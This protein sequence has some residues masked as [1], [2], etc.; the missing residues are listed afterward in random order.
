MNW[1]SISRVGKIVA[2]AAFFLPWMTVSCQGQPIATLNGVELATGLLSPETTDRLGNLD[3]GAG[4]IQWLV[5]VAAI[6]GIAGLVIGWRRFTPDP[7]RNALIASCVAAGCVFVSPFALEWGIESTLGM[8]GAGRDVS[9]AVAVDRQ[10]GFWVALAGFATAAFAWR[11]QR[12][13]NPFAGSGL[14]RQ[15]SPAGDEAA[16][17]EASA[18]A[19]S[20]SIRDYLRE[21]PVGRFREIAVDSLKKLGEQPPEPP[22]ATA[23]TNA[24][25]M[26]AGGGSRASFPTIKGLSAETVAPILLFAAALATIESLSWMLYAQVLDLYEGRSGWSPDLGVDPQREGWLQALAWANVPASIVGLLLAGVFRTKLRALSLIVAGTLVVAGV[27]LLPGLPGLW[28]LFIAPLCLQVAVAIVWCFALFS[29]AEKRELPELIFWFGGLVAMQAVLSFLLDGWLR[30]GWS[31]EQESTT[32]GA[33]SLLGAQ[34]IFRILCLALAAILVMLAVIWKRDASL[35]E[36][37]GSRSLS[38]AG[39]QRSTTGILLRDPA[40]LH[41]AI[42]LFLTGLFL[43][44][45]WQQ[46]WRGV[47]SA[48][49]EFSDSELMAQPI[50][51]WIRL[52][53]AIGVLTGALVVGMLSRQTPAWRGLGPA[54]ALAAAPIGILASLTSPNS[55]LNAV[56]PLACAYFP[57]AVVYAHL[58]AATDARHRF[59]AA[60]ASGILLLT[61]AAFAADANALVAFAVGSLGETGA[62]EQDIR[63]FAALMGAGLAFLW[64]SAHFLLAAQAISQTGRERRT[65]VPTLIA[66]GLA[67]PVS[68]GFLVWKH[69][70]GAQTALQQMVELVAPAEAPRQ[71][72][73]DLGVPPAD[74]ESAAPDPS[75]PASTPS[76]TDIETSDEYPLD[77]ITIKAG[78]T[79][80]RFRMDADCRLWFD[81]IE[82]SRLISRYTSRDGDTEVCEYGTMV[83]TSPSEKWAVTFGAKSDYGYDYIGIVSQRDNRII[84]TPAIFPNPDGAFVPGSRSSQR[85]PHQALR[86]LQVWTPDEEFLLIAEGLWNGL[87]CVLDVSKVTLACP[88]VAEVERAVVTA[89]RA[90]G[91]ACPGNSLDCG[92]SWNPG[93]GEMWFGDSNSTGVQVPKAQW[94][95]GDEVFEAKALGGFKSDRQSEYEAPVT[96]YEILFRLKTDG[97]LLDVSVNG[98]VFEGL[99]PQRPPSEDPVDVEPPAPAPPSAV[100]PPAD[101]R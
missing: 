58:A 100:P 48:N 61:P 50:I 51:Q 90:A 41:M 17:T 24:A 53:P 14:P 38:P 88:Q 31:P 67:I 80:G 60:I 12:R 71:L 10:F 84:R 40:S 47:F 11:Q 46:V 81:E 13:A 89:L 73:P 18:R 23:T 43:P 59:G 62:A 83:A 32:Q 39:G 35:A 74:P 27:L 66:L 56:L 101:Q 7:S 2:L 87:P 22:A 44:G 15:A 36:G 63:P 65:P 94:A 8:Q 92:P 54:L 98:P 78:G 85:Y 86:P 97:S 33:I 30:D 25:S 49:H 91:A 77:A 9:A 19:D 42:G 34:V 52:A 72:Q 96:G 82:V 79:L 6:A 76:E 69:V 26:A 57:V 70:P 1:V 3:V 55:G 93:P 37:N 45:L 20:R 29:V 5:L 75:A 21:F 4:Q 99:A 68:C 64:P 16:W 95:P 28:P